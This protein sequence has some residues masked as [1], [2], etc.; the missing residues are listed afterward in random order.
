V[1]YLIIGGGFFG[2]CV[3]LFL[4][5]ISSSIVIVEAGD[6]ILT[7]ASQ[8]NQARIHTGFHYPRSVLT[9]FKSLALRHRFAKVF[10]EAVFDGF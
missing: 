3:A 4:R 9:A 2:C 6:D 7:R 10:P 1:E 5:S 8:V